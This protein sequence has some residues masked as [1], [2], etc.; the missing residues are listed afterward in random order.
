MKGI[1]QDT[2]ALHRVVLPIFQQWI[3][4]VGPPAQVGPW[5]DGPHENPVGNAAD[6]DS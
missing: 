4:A 1:V 5:F 6:Q 2:F 3:R